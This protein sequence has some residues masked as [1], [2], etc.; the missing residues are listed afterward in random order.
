MSDMPYPTIRFD[1]CAD[2]WRVVSPFCLRTEIG[3]VTIRAGFGTDGASIPRLFWRM[4]GHPMTGDYIGAAVIHDGLY[5]AKL[6]GRPIADRVFYELLLG[7]GVG[8][9]RAGLMYGA[10]RAFGGLAWRTRRGDACRD[11]RR[12]VVVA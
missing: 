2:V 10:V 3:I 9:I 1:P 5:A 8:M 12:F 4:I 6:C 11:A 7:Y